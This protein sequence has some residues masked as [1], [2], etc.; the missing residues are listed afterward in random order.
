MTACSLL[1]YV[2]IMWMKMVPMQKLR[3]RMQF[4][5]MA[6]PW[7][8]FCI[9]VGDD[10]FHE[11]PFLHGTNISRYYFLQLFG[12]RKVWWAS[13]WLLQEKISKSSGTCSSIQLLTVY[14]INLANF[15]VTKPHQ[16]ID[17]PGMFQIWLFVLGNA[18]GVLAAVLSIC[19]FKNQITVK[20]FLGH[21]LTVIGQFFTMKLKG[22]MRDLVTLASAG[23]FL[24]FGY[25]GGNS[26]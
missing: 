13:Y 17:P 14:F 26:F 22:D 24:V 3:S 15:L 19:I 1:S 4:L 25:E 8:V 6:A 5:K 10:E 7:V 18:K 12:G 23:L 16:S 20:G 9:S 11:S 2:A 21:V